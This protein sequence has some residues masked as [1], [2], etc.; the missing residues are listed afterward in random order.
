MNPKKLWLSTALAPL[1]MAVLSGCPNT[2]DG[3]AKDSKNAGE[4][5]AQAAEKMGEKTSQMAT[6]VGESA[7]AMGKNAT[8]ALEVTPRVKTALTADVDLNDAKN[9]IDVDSKDGIVHLKGHVTTSALKKKA[10]EIAAKEIKDAG[11]T[12]KVMNQLLVK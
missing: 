9:H 6:G 2:A 7:K 3:M 10:G 5:S 1:L 11:G 12:D 4:A 8:A